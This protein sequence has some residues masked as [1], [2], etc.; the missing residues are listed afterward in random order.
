[1]DMSEA[2]T[3][4]DEH[5]KKRR[6]SASTVVHRTQSLRR[7]HREIGSLITTTS[8]ARLNKWRVKLDTALQAEQI[9]GAKIR[10]DVA[11]LR[12]FYDALIA[13]G[14]ATHNPARDFSIGPPEVWRPRPATNPDVE[15]LYEVITGPEE[16]RDR[17]LIS[18]YLNGFRRVEVCRMRVAGLRYA[19]TEQTVVV[20][21]VGKGGDVGEV[22]LNPTTGALLA[23]YV[24]AQYV[25]E[26]GEWIKEFQ[27][28]ATDAE[29]S[30]EAEEA[31]AWL[32]VPMLALDRYL[33]SNPEQELPVFTHLGKPL[34]VRESNRIFA[35]YRKAA[36]LPKYQAQSGVWKNIGPHSLRHTCATELLEAG[37]DSRVVQ[38]ILRHKNIT[39]T[40]RYMLV[41]TGPQAAA[42]RRLAMPVRKAVKA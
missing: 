22:P 9:S 12:T 19:P 26:H 27:A 2:F 39:T 36:D 18:L 4:Y 40:Q 38:T 41:R 15:R 11:T 13:A 14:K 8:A 23:E 16:L 29:Y 30:T 6:L 28:R 33:R 42:M 35:K 37:V 5:L 17:T 10:N 20:R 3:V 31:L 7:L 32:Q 34:T 1:M 21:V 25:P 24:L